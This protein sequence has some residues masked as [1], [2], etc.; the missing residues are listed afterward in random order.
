MAALRAADRT[1]LRAALHDALVFPR[2]VDRL[3]AFPKILRCRLLHVHV[4]AGLTRPNR[5]Q[6]VPI[7]LRGVRHHVHVLAVQQCPHV[8]ALVG[9]VSILL[10]EAF[11]SARQAAAVRIAQGH[12]LHPLLFFHARD[13]EV[14]AARAQ[15]HH[16]H[17]NRVV[18]PKYARRN[19]QWRTDRRGRHR[20]TL[21]ELPS[22]DRHVKA[23]FWLH[24]YCL[25]S[26]STAVGPATNAESIRQ[27]R[28]ESTPF[29]AAHPFF[30]LPG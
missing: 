17:A 30:C 19:H 23:P 29:Y 20:R 26:Y 12:D 6:T 8:G 1:L 10:L 16:G 18:G 15:A 3:L 13:M 22:I 4:L 25:S 2:G 28:H 5:A 14:D 21:Q 27:F 9:R 7:R 24:P 11:R